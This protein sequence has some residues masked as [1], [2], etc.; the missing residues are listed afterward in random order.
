MNGAY[1][2]PNFLRSVLWAVPIT[3]LLCV[4]GDSESLALVHGGGLLVLLFLPV[5]PVILLFG[6]GGLF[7]PAPEWAFNSL[8]IGSEFVWVLFVVH[9][10]RYLRWR[11]I[12][13]V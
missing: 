4:W 5:I 8:A 2:K 1:E 13:A 10:V 12:R 7:F 3:V 6:S 9:L 11:K